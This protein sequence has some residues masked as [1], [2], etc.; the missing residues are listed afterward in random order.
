MFVKLPKPFIL[1]FLSVIVI[2]TLNASTINVAYK[3][4]N[5]YDYFKA[6]KLFYK[7]N[8]K[9]IN[10]FASFGLATIYFRNDNPFFNLDSASKYINLSYNCFI[11]KQKPT[12]FF[13]FK[14][15]SLSI[16]KMAD[17][18]A[19]KAFEVFKKNNTVTAYNQFLKNNYLANSFILNAAVY[20]RDELEFNATLSNN[21]SQ[22]TQFF[23]NT[24]PQSNF[25]ADAFLQLDR[26]IYFETTKNQ[27]AQDYILFLKTYPKN[28]MRQAAFEKLFQIYKEQ[29]SVAGLTNFVN[30]YPKAP[31]NIE[32]WKLLF[33]LS[34]KA[35][36]NFELE[37]F[38]AI[39]PNFPLKNSILN[40]L[41]LN[42]IQLLSYQKNDYFGFVDTSA[43]P[44]IEAIYDAVT[45]F[46]EGLSVVTKNDSV[47]FINKKNQN[48]FNQF[49][50]DAYS[51]NNG[52]TA[53]KQ[54]NTWLFINRQGQ[55]IT[56]TFEEVNELSNAI[57][58]VK[59]NNKYGALNNYGQV[60][61]EPKF[62]KLGD[63]KNDFAYYIENGKYGFVTKNGLVKKAQYDW[64]SDMGNDTIA[65]MKQN[66]KYGLVTSTDSIIIPPQF[67]QII[68]T[69]NNIYILVKDNLYGYYYSTLHCYLTQINYE[70]IKEKPVEFYTNGTILK[71]LKNKQQAF[72]DFNGKLT[73]DFGTYDEINFASNNLIKVKR[74]NKYGYLDRKLNLVVPYKYQQA[75]D[76]KDSLAIVQ[77][78]DK[79]SL[80]SVFGKEIYSSEYDIEKIS[81]HYY[82]INS[83][84][85]TLINN[86]GNVVFTQIETIQKAE[87][88][89]LIITLKN[90]SIKLIYD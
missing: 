52:I 88:S 72:A 23:I 54:N 18:I 42:K 25:V 15:D 48:V 5:Q 45:S 49:Y 43:T 10:S 84:E 51:F 16:L 66:N 73:I 44:V 70:Y 9:Q 79:I 26:Q 85:K 20:L 83:P 61:I 14:I 4:L 80:I 32:A 50:T 47:Y 76:F 33:S 36:S 37:K 67:D 34:V 59:N 64:I 55:F 21:L 53:V 2:R 24:H 7:V 60:L 90:N 63:F 39:H 40:E 27:H 30:N 71:L 89:C 82:V 3:S 68:K 38:L 69:K 75:S 56:N 31:Q 11:Y 17:S 86:K 12:Q 78:K 58:I 13:N 28:N 74:K 87:T 19:N 35:F 57:Y 8:K 41:E 77:L 6:K 1:F 65:I 46:K 22:A 29:S 81:A 62:E